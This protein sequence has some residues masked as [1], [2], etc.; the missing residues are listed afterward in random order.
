MLCSMRC[1]TMRPDGPGMM[2]V[3]CQSNMAVGNPVEMEAKISW[4]NHPQYQPGQPGINKP[5]F[6]YVL[7]VVFPPMVI[8]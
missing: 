8:I 1:V 2:M 6:G 5:W 7:M 4:E 3:L